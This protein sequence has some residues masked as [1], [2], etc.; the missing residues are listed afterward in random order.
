MLRNSPKPNFT[1]L[2]WL[3]LHIILLT[4]DLILAA[5]KRASIGAV[6]LI[7]TIAQ[8]IKCQG[9]RASGPWRVVNCAS[10]ASSVS[11]VDGVLLVSAE[12]RYTNIC[13]EEKPRVLVTY[14]IEIIL[15]DNRQSLR[16]W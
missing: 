3:R 12:F 8:A 13:P 6:I 1:R 11:F 7:L 2:S 16:Y 15:E 4:F 5:P 14:L 9:K 10:I